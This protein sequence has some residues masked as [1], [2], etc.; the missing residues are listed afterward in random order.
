MATPKPRPPRGHF[1]FRSLPCHCAST[2]VTCFARGLPSRLSP[3][4]DLT[5]SPWRAVK[6]GFKG[7]RFHDLRGAYET[8]LLDAGEALHVVARR[9][10]LLSN[11]AKRTRKAD[12]GAA[13]TINGLF[14]GMLGPAIT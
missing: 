4:V 14:K 9:G 6:L 11:Y 2:T 10:V 5:R 3:V 12:K 13:K 7:L 8:A 1:L